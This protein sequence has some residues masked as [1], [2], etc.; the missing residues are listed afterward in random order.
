MKYCLTSQRRKNVDASEQTKGLINISTLEKGLSALKKSRKVNTAKDDNSRLQKKLFK[1]I[2][3]KNLA[4]VTIKTIS[5]G[6]CNTV[7]NAYTLYR[8]LG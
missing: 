6:E 7:L 3:E 1:A 2:E 8:H 5:L 4:E